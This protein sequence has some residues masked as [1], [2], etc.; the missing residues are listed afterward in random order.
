VLFRTLP[1]EPKSIKERGIIEIKNNRVKNMEIKDI[2]ANQGNIDVV[3][4]I[5]TKDEPRT[6][7][8][9]GKQGRVCNAKAKDESGEITLTLWNDDVDVVNV[10]DKIHLQNGW[11]SEYKG[12]RQL[13]SGKFGKIEV[14]GKGGPQ[15]VFTNDPGIAAGGLPE[16][17]PDAQPEAEEAQVSPEEFIE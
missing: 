11:C 3:V 14:V 2:Q 17:Q 7:E 5:T 6:F 13:S 1:S 4:E 10:G 15:E 9:F 12:E 16:A 8:K